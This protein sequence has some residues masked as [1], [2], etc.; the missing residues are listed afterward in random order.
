M[1]GS[2]TK[3]HW[4]GSFQDSWN[5]VEGTNASIASTTAS[6]GAHGESRSSESTEMGQPALS[7]P[8]GC[9]CRTGE[10]L[11]PSASPCDTS[12]NRKTNDPALAR[13]GKQ[14][15]PWLWPLQGPK[16]L[17]ASSNWSQLCP[18]H[19]APGTWCL[20]QRLALS[21]AGSALCICPFGAPCKVWGSRRCWEQVGAGKQGR[22]KAVR[23]LP[24]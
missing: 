14:L 11:C 15:R 13:S 19:A 3:I 21:P 24:N 12:G 16:C 4:A 2:T 1:I 6:P 18:W 22:E 5:K 7:L 17:A 23:T 9:F 10:K 20:L 8:Y